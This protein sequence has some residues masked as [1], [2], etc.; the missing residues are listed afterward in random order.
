MPTPV[1]TVTVQE[2]QQQQQQQQQQ[3]EESD[4]V[5]DE[6]EEDEQQCDQSETYSLV[7]FGALRLPIYNGM[8]ILN[9]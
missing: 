1:V 5:V 6:G 8:S 9:T 3:E 4:D 2:S 7:D